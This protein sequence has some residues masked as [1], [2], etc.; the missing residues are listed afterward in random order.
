M[1][2]LFLFF[3]LLFFAFRGYIEGQV[4]TTPGVRT[5]HNFRWYHQFCILRDLSAI[6]AG[7]TLAPAL[8]PGALVIGW[9][10]TEIMYSVGRYRR[11]D[12]S[13]EQIWGI[14]WYVT[15]RWVKALHIGRGLVGIA[16]IIGGI[17]L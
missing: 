8:V 14:G 15:D 9:E 2:V 17:M 6:A 7:V 10:I 4:M 3:A 16:L 5:S 13:Y 1:T 11:V 12:Y